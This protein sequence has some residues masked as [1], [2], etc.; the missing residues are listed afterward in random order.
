MITLLS[1]LR[2]KKLIIQELDNEAYRKK[3]TI[4]L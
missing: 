4:S 2:K 1:R 3:L